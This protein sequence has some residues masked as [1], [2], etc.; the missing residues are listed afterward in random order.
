MLRHIV[1]KLVAQPEVVICAAI[2]LSDG[3]LARGHRHCHCVRL[4]REDWRISNDEAML[5]EQGF[6]TSCNRFVGREEALALQ[7][8]AGIP[9]HDPDGYRHSELFSEDLY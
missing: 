4:I 9:S 3:R 7:K 8:S 1:P 2:R 5:A 6:I